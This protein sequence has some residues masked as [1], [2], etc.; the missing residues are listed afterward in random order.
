M[1]SS[2]GSVLVNLFLEDF[3]NKVISSCLQPKLWKRYVEDILTIW[4]HGK[5][6][7]D[8]YFD[9]LNSMLASMKFTMEIENEHN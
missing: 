7:L 6:L 5:E 2:L 4:S 1:G 3:E 9:L 8:S